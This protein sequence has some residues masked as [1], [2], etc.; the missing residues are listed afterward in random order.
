MKNGSNGFKMGTLVF[1]AGVNNR[2]ADDLNFSKFVVASIRRH[3]AGDWGDLCKE[4]KEAN[5][6]ALIFESRLLSAYQSGPV[7]IWIITE[8]DRSVTTVLFP[9]EY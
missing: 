2:V 4:D 5:E 7:K 6:A 1:T 3:A 8:W 9:D